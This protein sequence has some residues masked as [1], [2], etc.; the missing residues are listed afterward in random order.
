MADA[1]RIQSS[2]HFNFLLTICMDFQGCALPVGDKLFE[3]VGQRLA[4][5]IDAPHS[6]CQHAAVAHGHHICGGEACRHEKE[7][8]S[9][10]MLNELYAYASANL[11]PCSNRTLHTDTEVCRYVKQNYMQ[12]ALFKHIINKAFP[13]PAC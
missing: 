10:A 1:R 7:G 13:Q 5:H 4:A 11:G 3:V 8:V 2:K 12:E 9:I 6:C